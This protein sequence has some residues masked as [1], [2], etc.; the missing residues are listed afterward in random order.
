MANCSALRF[1]S[2]IFRNSIS[3]R[4]LSNF[5]KSSSEGVSYNIT[6]KEDLKESCIVKRAFHVIMFVIVCMQR[7][8]QDLSMWGWG[9]G[10][11]ELSH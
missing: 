9:G 4:G 10:R 7:C 6:M 8:S 3:T 5:A 11:E 1:N 2:L